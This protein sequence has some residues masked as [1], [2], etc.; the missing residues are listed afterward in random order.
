MDLHGK[1]CLCQQPPATGWGVSCAEIQCVQLIPRWST[2]SE[3]GI[4]GDR[5]LLVQGE[6]VTR[7]G[8]IATGGRGEAGQSGKSTGA[9][10]WWLQ[11]FKGNRRLLNGHKAL[12]EIRGC[13]AQVSACT[14]AGLILRRRGSGLGIFLQQLHPKGK[15]EAAPQPHTCLI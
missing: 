6:E 15:E 1:P 12:K 3:W 14:R 8:T 11:H 2:V 9:S 4:H 5:L 7:L 13:E 10:P